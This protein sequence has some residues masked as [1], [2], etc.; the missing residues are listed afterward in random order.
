MFSKNGANGRA[1][2]SFSGGAA[3]VPIK[4]RFMLLGGLR[5]E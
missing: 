3:E 5:E 4:K 2:D 1:H